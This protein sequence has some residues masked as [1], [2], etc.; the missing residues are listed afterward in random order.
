MS[1]ETYYEGLCRVPRCRSGSA[2]YSMNTACE[3]TLHATA[4]T[5]NRT[6]KNTPLNIEDEV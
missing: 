5:Y 3:L 1:Y 2:E 6:S 4:V